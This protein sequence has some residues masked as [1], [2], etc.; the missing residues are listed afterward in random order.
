VV[1]PQ[2]YD[3]VETPGEGCGVK[4]HVK[5]EEKPWVRASDMRGKG[6]GFPRV[7]GSAFYSIK[8]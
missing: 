1:I 4:I 8:I 3:F 5:N 2:S 6:L 7:S